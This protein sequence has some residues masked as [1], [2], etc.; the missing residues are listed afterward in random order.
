M[1]R[2]ALVRQRAPSVATPSSR[3][4]PVPPVMTH[5]VKRWPGDATRAE[6]QGALQ[7]A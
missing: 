7:V 1:R 6:R 5:S 2:R 4:V 3:R